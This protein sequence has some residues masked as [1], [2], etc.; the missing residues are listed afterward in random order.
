MPDDGEEVKRGDGDGHA[1]ALKE[2]QSLREDEQGS[3]HGPD[4]LGG[5]DRCVDGDRDVLHAEV[6]RN[7]G[8]QYDERF[9]KDQ[10]MG[11]PR[12]LGDEDVPFFRLLRT[13]IREEQDGQEEQEGD[14]DGGR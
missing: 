14:E 10:E 8:P 5:P 4:G 3:K 11:G 9:E 12:D 13:F 6:G 1:D 7:P 2:R